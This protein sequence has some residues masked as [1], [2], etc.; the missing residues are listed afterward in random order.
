M[1]ISIAKDFSPWPI[2]RVREDG[3][4][5]GEAFREDFLVPKL[6][7]S[8]PAS[9]LIVDLN[10]AEGYPSSFLEESF[11][12]LVQKEYYTAAE[13]KKILRIEADGGYQFYRDVIWKYI[14]ATS[15]DRK[16]EDGCIMKISIAKD[17]SPWPVGRVREDGDATGEAFREDFLVPKLKESSPASP[18]IVDLNGAEGY[19][20][21]FLEESFGGLVRKKYYTAATLEK[22]LKI[23]ADSGYQFYRDIIWD[24]INDASVER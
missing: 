14:N 5:T 22:I 6:K 2:G 13:L 11:G 8:S 1:K 7:E 19:P 24:Y 9:P 21:A 18:L 12:G 10:G 20:S 15:T 3:D 17:F 16:I 4:A 23:E